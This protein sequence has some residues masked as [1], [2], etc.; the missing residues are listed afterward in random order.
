MTLTSWWWL[1]MSLINRLADWPP[2]C[3][4]TARMFPQ[5]LCTPHSINKLTLNGPAKYTLKNQPNGYVHWRKP[6]IIS[7]PIFFS[8]IGNCVQL[9]SLDLQHN[10]LLDIPESIGNLKSLIRLGLRWVRSWKLVDCLNFGLYNTVD[11]SQTKKNVD[12]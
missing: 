4:K 3:H 10:E 9:N 11:S 6:S 5:I 12:L 1:V 8:E 7:V 2:N